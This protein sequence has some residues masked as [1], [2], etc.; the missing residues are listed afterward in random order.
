MTVEQWEKPIETAATA[1][2][3]AADHL[4]SISET[5]EVSFQDMSRILNMLQAAEAVIRLIPDSL[6]NLRSYIQE[7]N[8]P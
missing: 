7:R 8:R 1:L 3:T 5:G 2:R 6:E 4:E